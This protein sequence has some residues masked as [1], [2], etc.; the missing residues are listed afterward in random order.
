MQNGMGVKNAQR[1]R[2]RRRVKL[3]MTTKATIN[4]LTLAPCT[5]YTVCLSTSRGQPGNRQ[6]N[7]QPPGPNMRPDFDA[8]QTFEKMV[9][10]GVGCNCSTHLRLARHAKPTR[11]DRG[12]GLAGVMQF[13]MV[14]RTRSHSYHIARFRHHAPYVNV[15]GASASPC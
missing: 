7:D 8:Q 1:A 6:E 11:F 9:L 4:T 15:S 10:D 14:A 3:Y 2:I 13:L 5:Q 12:H